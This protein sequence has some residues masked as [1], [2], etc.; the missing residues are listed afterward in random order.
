MQ[1]LWTLLPA[2]RFLGGGAGEFLFREAGELPPALLTE[3]EHYQ[4]EASGLGM[5]GAR[6]TSVEWLEALQCPGPDG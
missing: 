5:E 6:D 4:P 2:G 3:P 1:P